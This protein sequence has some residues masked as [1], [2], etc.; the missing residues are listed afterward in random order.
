MHSVQSTITASSNR[1]ADERVLAELLG[2]AEHRVQHFVTHVV[3]R[4]PVRALC[5]CARALSALNEIPLT[6]GERELIARPHADFM[7]NVYTAMRQVTSETNICLAQLAQMY[8]LVADDKVGD[9]AVDA[10]TH[11]ELEWDAWDAD[12]GESGAASGAKSHSAGHDVAPTIAALGQM[13][14]VENAR[15]VRRIR[16]QEDRWAV[17]NEL[18]DFHARCSACIDTVVTTCLENCADD[19]MRDCELPHRRMRGERAAQARALATRL[20]AALS[21]LLDQTLTGESLAAD[22]LSEATAL[23]ARENEQPGYRQ[24]RAVLKKEFVRFEDELAAMAEDTNLDALSQSLDGFLRFLELMRSNI[25]CKELEDYDRRQLTQALDLCSAG[26]AASDLI[27]QL[28]LQLGC[29][30]GLDPYLLPAAGPE[31]LDASTALVAALESAS[32]GLNG[33]HSSC[34]W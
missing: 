24:L 8:P 3:D 29:D 23:L 25:Q 31:L 28:Q 11:D 6:G 20:H 15:L 9:A 34:P 17:L 19:E 26:V 27:E 21:S 30:P 16:T 10:E 22:I 18:Q 7:S 2:R 4:T 13:L 32:A 14:R 12:A 1:P 33:N 5:C